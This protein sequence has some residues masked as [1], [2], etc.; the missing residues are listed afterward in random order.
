MTTLIPKFNLKDG[1]STPAGAVNR[2]IF[3]KLK[4]FISVLDFGATGNGTTDDTDAIQAAIDG[5]PAGSILYFPAGSYL[6]T[7]LSVVKNISLVGEGS[8]SIIKADTP[9]NCITVNMPQDQENNVVISGFKFLGVDTNLE[10][11]IYVD[12]IVNIIIEHCHFSDSSCA[13]CINHRYGYGLLIDKCVFN[14][15]DSNGILLQGVGGSTTAYTFISKI[16]DCDF[17]RLTGSAILTGVLQSLIVDSCVMQGCGQNAYACDANSVNLGVTFL[18]CWWEGNSFANIFIGANSSASVTVVNP[19]M[20]GTPYIQINNNTRLNIIGIQGGGGSDPCTIYG[21]AGSTVNILGNELWVKNGD[22]ELNGVGPGVELNNGAF[23]NTFSTNSSSGVT[24][25]NG[26]NDTTL[27]I[28]APTGGVKKAALNLV[29][30]GTNAAGFVYQPS[31]NILQVY[32]QTSGTGVSLAAGGTSWG[33]YSD[34]RLKENLIPIPD[35][36]AKVAKLRAVT[37]RY[38]TD[39][40]D[41]SRSFLIAQDVLTVLP[42][43]VD[44]SDKDALSLRYADVI[45]LLVAS[46]K[47]LKAEVDALKA[48]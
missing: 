37:G 5:V 35:A 22:Y 7:E 28:T 1:G 34:E 25:L 17:T 3:L 13:Y 4:E 39:E 21:S 29:C 42:E 15:L 36:L 19:C 48:K 18:N 14:D 38:K 12:E 47:E 23:S 40:K 24:Q 26:T 8:G 11:F 31:T 41:V 10:S 45:P 30:T 20:N 43:A 46:I 6:V 33:S 2:S 9:N 16:R 44:T 27:Q 32:N